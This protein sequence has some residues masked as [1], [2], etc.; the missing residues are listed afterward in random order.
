MIPTKKSHVVNQGGVFV[1]HADLN[2]P[3]TVPEE[4]RAGGLKL[5]REWLNWGPMDPFSGDR[6]TFCV[7]LGLLGA[8][9]VSGCGKHA[10]QVPPPVDVQ[11]A[12]VE[13]R[14]VPVVREWVG[15]L[16]GSVNAQIRAQVS[17]YLLKQ[18]YQEGSAVAKGDPLFEIDPR[19]FA[20][21]LAQAEAL[22]AQAQAQLGKAAQDVARYTPLAEDKA[23]SQEVLDNAVQ[24][25][26]AADA[27]VASARAAVDQANLNLSFTHI[28]AP[29]DG[30]AGLV[31]TQIGDLVGPTTGILT[32][33]STVDPIKAYFP[34]SEQAYLEFRRRAPDAPSIPTGTEFELV[35]SDGSSYPLKGAFFAIDRQVDSN[36]GTL[37][38]AAMFPNPKGLLRPGQFARVRAVVSVNQG[39]L[40][41]PARAL[42]ELQGGYQVATVDA[43]NHA[44]IV[45]VKV[46]EQIGALRVVE[47]L[48]P[49]DRVIAEGLQKVKDGTVVNP[50][51]FN[52]AEAAK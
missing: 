16:D 3:P 46:G 29:V 48:H 42:T 9:L 23:V 30:I 24:A 50:L 19:P 32:T 45:T 44:H 15:S 35:L 4:I 14:D 17:G 11:V 34:I 41:V 8:G 27:Q 31:Q 37:R 47:G 25:R 10:D 6:K 38:V 33:V 26:L 2:F 36:T 49:G 12:A 1:N 40:L 22:L 18:D 52:P 39:A 28:A 20:S 13:Q 5:Q 43:G 21:A 7:F 51:P